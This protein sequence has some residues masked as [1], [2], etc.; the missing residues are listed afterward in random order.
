MVRIRDAAVGEFDSSFW[1]F[2]ASEYS[3]IQ[4]W[5]SCELWAD[6]RLEEAMNIDRRT[7]RV[8]HPAYVELRDAIHA[9]LRSVFSEV[10]SRIYE[11]G[12][13]AKKASRAREIVK[14]IASVMEEDGT[15]S[16][17]TVK[18]VVTAWRNNS[19]TQS[20][21]LQKYSVDE[22]YGIIIEITKEILTN[23]Q[24]GEFLRRLTER[25]A[26]G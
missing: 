12:S 7:L 8:T 5:V 19:N 26:S 16:A 23:K 15:L 9:Q 13:K 2:S 11:S 14:E 1:G 6:D 25:L 4:R 18:S 24:R 3:L 22:L 10:R 17:A 20:A 21:V